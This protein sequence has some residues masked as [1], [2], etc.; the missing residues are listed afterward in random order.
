MFFVLVGRLTD[1]LSTRLTNIKERSKWKPLLPCQRTDDIFI[2]KRQCPPPLDGRRLSQLT[3]QV[4]SR[5]NKLFIIY[6]FFGMWIFSSSFLEIADREKS[7]EKKTW[8]YWW[9]WILKMTWL[10][11]WLL[12]RYLTWGEK[13]V[14]INV[15]PDKMY[16][17]SYL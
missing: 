5:D 12:Q 14:F 7:R 4:L 16:L 10:N 11:F 17:L 9:F 2:I 1:L 13:S 15:T 3:C 8:W 6:Y